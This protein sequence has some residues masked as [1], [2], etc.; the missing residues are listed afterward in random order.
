MQA[1]A[2]A[3]LRLLQHDHSVGKFHASINETF[4]GIESS[5]GGGGK[6]LHDPI[7]NRLGS[8]RGI[9]VI[10]FLKTTRHYQRKESGNRWRP[11][12]TPVIGLMP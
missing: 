3:Y 5:R 1:G 10:I 6:S 12:L 7:G 9:T 4:G 8:L 2:V 11:A